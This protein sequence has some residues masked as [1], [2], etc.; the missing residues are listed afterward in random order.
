MAMLRVIFFD[1]AG[2]L[3]H[4]P[5]GVGHHYAEVARRHGADLDPAAL[6]QAF[7]VAWKKAA[8]PPETR[9]AR[10]DD[11]RGWWRALAREAFAKLDAAAVLERCFDELWDEFARPGVWELFPETREVLD[12]LGGRYRLGV[13][14]NFDTRL[15]KILRDLGIGDRFEHVV[16]SSQVGA[17]KPSAHIFNVALERFGVAAAEAL[18]IG[19]EPEADWRA[20]TGAG[21]R[22]FELRR[23]ENSLREVFDILR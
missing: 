12:V 22:A 9:V 5:R 13:V 23:P 3:F 7:R 16:V 15:L 21:L 1:A 8:A 19:D 10:P 4:L 18:H 6:E 14:S 17:E 11:D 20:A 2:T